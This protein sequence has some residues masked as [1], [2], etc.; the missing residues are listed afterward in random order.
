MSIHR[1]ANRAKHSGWTEHGQETGWLNDEW[2]HNFAERVEDV[3]DSAVTP[4]GS[5][6]GQVAMEVEFEVTPGRRCRVVARGP[7]RHIGT[8]VSS[9]AA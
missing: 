2:E 1:R 4:R 6:A 9:G 3:A 5:V 7:C 8:E